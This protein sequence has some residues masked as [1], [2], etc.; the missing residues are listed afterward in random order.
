MY[1]WFPTALRQFAPL[2]SGCEQVLNRWNAA[3]DG[4]LRGF[5][6]FHRD[7]FGEAA[8]QV[9]VRNFWVPTFPCDASG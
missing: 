5:A 9:A 1:P 2:R 8:Q 7:F 6:V 4:R 3:W